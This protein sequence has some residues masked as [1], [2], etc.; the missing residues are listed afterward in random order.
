M[1]RL[2]HGWIRYTETRGVPDRRQ[3]TL[4][5]EEALQTEVV[6]EAQRATRVHVARTQPLHGA[7]EKRQR[8]DHL[9]RNEDETEGRKAQGRD[10]LL[11]WARVRCGHGY[12]T[13]CCHGH[14]YAVVVDTGRAV[15]MDTGTLLSWIRD[16]LSLGIREALRR[17]VV[18]GCVQLEPHCRFSQCKKTVMAQRDGCAESAVLFAPH[19]NPF[20]KSQTR[21]ATRVGKHDQGRRQC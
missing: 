2:T 3:R 12:G 5:L 7:Q 17:D 6:V 13:R 19:L 16:V 10:M 15:V 9:Q 4:H 18:V 20:L 21:H 1:V 14:G 8:R 11:S